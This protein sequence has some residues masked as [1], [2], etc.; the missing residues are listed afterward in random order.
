MQVTQSCLTPRDPM[1]CSPSGPLFIRFLRQENW[2]GQPFPSPGDLPD[3]AIESRSPALQEN[4]LLSEPPGKTKTFEKIPKEIFLR[5]LKNLFC[6]SFSVKKDM[7][8]TSLSSYKISTFP[9]NHLEYDSYRYLFNEK[10][11]TFLAST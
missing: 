6:N 9:L 5:N 7:N 2:S 8:Q 4:L 3:P 11:N 10:Q 1:D